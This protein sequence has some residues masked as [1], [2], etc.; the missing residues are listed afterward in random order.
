MAISW[1]LTDLQPPS[2]SDWI[3]LFEENAS[4]RKYLKYIYTNC[5]RE[6]MDFINIPSNPGIFFLPV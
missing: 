4:N 6:G 3:G 5:S 2:D 1:A